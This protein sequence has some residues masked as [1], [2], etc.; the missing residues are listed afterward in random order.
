[1]KT[2][3]QV[4]LHVFCVREHEAEGAWIMQETTAWSSPRLQLQRGQ[5]APVAEPKRKWPN[6]N[7]KCCKVTSS[8]VQQGGDC[9]PSW[10]WVCVCVCERLPCVLAHLWS[11]CTTVL[12]VWGQETAVASEVKVC[13]VQPFE[14]YSALLTSINQNCTKLRL[15][16]KQTTSC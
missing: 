11:C 13:S 4:W 16:L 3:C 15:L 2:S 1:M 14:G 12:A 5:H 10:G 7:R 8:S 9:M 6:S